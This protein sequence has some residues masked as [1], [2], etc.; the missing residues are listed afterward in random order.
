MIFFIDTMED[1]DPMSSKLRLDILSKTLCEKPYRTLK[2]CP[3]LRD[4]KTAATRCPQQWNAFAE[5]RDARVRE[6]TE[7]CLVSGGCD[8]QRAAYFTCMEK[9]G[10]D[11]SDEAGVAAHTK[12]EK[13]FQESLRCGAKS[14]LEEF[15]HNKAKKLAQ[16]SMNK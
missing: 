1:D 4:L 9:N 14:V 8:P 15:D 11:A 3:H 10:A 13:L 16:A 7:W 5:C 12:C 6:V 2:K